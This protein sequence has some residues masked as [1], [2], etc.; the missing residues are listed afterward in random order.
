MDTDV[1]ANPGDVRFDL[2]PG[3]GRYGTDINVADFVQVT[4]L[5]PA[6]LG[7]AE[8]YNGPPCPWPQ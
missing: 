3:P 1:G 6:M 4:N 5:N 8:A 7:G 2:V